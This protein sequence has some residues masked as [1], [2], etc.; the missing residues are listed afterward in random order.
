MG[1]GEWRSTQAVR[2]GCAIASHDRADLLCRDCIIQIGELS[3][4]RWAAYILRRYSSKY[5]SVFRNKMVDRLRV[6]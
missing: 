5:K 6:A 3:R 2:M 4:N 1:D